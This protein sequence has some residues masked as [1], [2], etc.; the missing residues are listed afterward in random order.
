M[1]TIRVA[2][3][4]D[5]E[6]VTEVSDLAIAILRKTYR[7]KKA[8]LINKPQESSLRIGWVALMHGRVVGTVQYAVEEDC[9]H[10]IGLL[11]HPHFQRQGVA[12]T[13]FTYHSRLIAPRKPRQK[14]FGPE[15]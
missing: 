3:P 9:I 4:E 12:R 13:L 7:P 5:A 11:V 10:L 14:A 8:T 15:I 1:M 2:V 6:A